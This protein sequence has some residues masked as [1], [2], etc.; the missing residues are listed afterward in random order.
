MTDHAAA[1]RAAYAAA[2]QECLDAGATYEAACEAVSLELRTKITAQQPT[3][4]ARILAHLAATGKHNDNAIAAAL[5][6]PIGAVYEALEHLRETGAVA[7]QWSYGAWWHWAPTTAAYDETSPDWDQETEDYANSHGD[8]TISTLQEAAPMY[9][10]PAPYS[11]AEALRDS[12]A[13]ADAE[14]AASF[15]RCDTDGFLSQWAS[16]INANLDRA[17]ADLLDAGGVADFPAL[18]DLDGRLVPAKLVGTRY[19]VAW[20]LLPSDN[21]HSAF[22]GWFNPSAAEDPA[23]A[24]KANAR[25][26][27]YVGAVAAPAGARIAASGR[28][29]SGCASA[30][31]QTYRTDG[32]FSRAVTITDSG[33][34]G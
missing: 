9:S 22:S 24:R 21:P 12:A 23:R 7:S 30:Y 10:T 15:E 16:G 33:Q 28:G 20:G 29:L 13:A 31:V 34:E 17:K 27:Y 32:G 18:F 3:P 4:A 8:T 25:K 26:G 14:A 6:L 1:A 19:G 5:G 11:L 2:I